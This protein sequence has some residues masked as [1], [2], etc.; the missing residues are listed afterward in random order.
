MAIV[1]ILGMQSVH[2]NLI[3][4]YAPTADAAEQSIVTRA[5]VAGDLGGTYLHAYSANN[6]NI[7]TFW[8]DVDDGTNKPNN[9]AVNQTIVVEVDI[10]ENATANA[11]ATALRAGVNAQADFTG[12]GATDTVTI[13]N[14][15]NGA[16][17]TPA[18]GEKSKPTNF[19][20]SQT[21]K[22]ITAIP[23]AGAGSVNFL[24][25]TGFIWNTEY[26][27]QGEEGRGHVPFAKHA[28]DIIVPENKITG[29]IE[30]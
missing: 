1:K 19:V 18:D 5:D 2:A 11:V 7:Y 26:V 30:N 4:I 3:E 9:A 29:I 24:H 27:W 25:I 23:A 20:F 6:T 13:V 12:G 22:G 15:A 14:A 16:A 28:V 21:T 17:G 8:F 10:V